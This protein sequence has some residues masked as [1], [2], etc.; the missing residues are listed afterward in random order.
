M[1]DQIKA[2]AQVSERYREACIRAAAPGQKTLMV[3]ARGHGTSVIAYEAAKR[4]GASNALFI[5]DRAQI[6]SWN[7]QLSQAGVR[8]VVVPSKKDAALELCRDAV[9][10]DGDG[11]TV[12]LAAP[13]HLAG[14][15]HWYD[16]WPEKSPFGFVAVFD[17]QSYAST[18]SEKGRGLATVI[19][20]T[21]TA[22][23]LYDQEGIDPA[24][25]EAIR[26][27]HG[28]VVCR[29]GIARTAASACE[30]MCMDAD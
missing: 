15:G 13:S 12:Y 17:I 16:A 14:I 27:E 3:F 21:D 18:R 4:C 24:R 5:A 9:R 1:Q 26:A 10:D 6:E 20:R 8:T 2:M 19:R 7:Y 23:L 28:A 25:V 11:L 29:P 30:A 22:L